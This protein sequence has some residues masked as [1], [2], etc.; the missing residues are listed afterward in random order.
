MARIAT[1]NRWLLAGAVTLTGAIALI[2]R[3]SFHGHT[4]NTAAT[5]PANSSAAATAAQS[6]QSAQTANPGDSIAPPDQPP[7]AS[8]P[9]PSVVVSGGS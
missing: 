1:A 8:L 3:S 4:L 5:T 7:V 9:D 6:N 2:A